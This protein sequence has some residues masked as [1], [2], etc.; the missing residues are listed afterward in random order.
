MLGDGLFCAM[1]LIRVFLRLTQGCL[2]GLK[3]GKTPVNCLICWVFLRSRLEQMC[4]FVYTKSEHML[5]LIC[6]PDASFLHI[7]LF[8]FSGNKGYIA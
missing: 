5:C 4:F 6:T 1:K 7:H 8:C 3:T 2:W